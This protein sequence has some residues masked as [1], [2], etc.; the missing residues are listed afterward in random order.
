MKKIAILI[1]AI[2]VV[3]AIFIVLGKRA[4]TAPTYPAGSCAN[5]YCQGPNL[6]PHS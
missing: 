6:T 3:G 4:A 2:G 1:V 5:G